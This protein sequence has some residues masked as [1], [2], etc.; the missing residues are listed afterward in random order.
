VRD[1]Q[2]PGSMPGENI[3]HLPPDVDALFLEARQAMSTNAHTAAVLAFRKLLMHIAVDCGAQPSESFVAYVQ[4][5]EDNHYVPPRAK[6]WVDRIR[7]RG[8]EANHQITLMAK[9]QSEELLAITQMLL[10]LV[11]EYPAIGASP[12]PQNP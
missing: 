7:Q 1:I 3:K 2:F 11:Y 5:L 9:E 8:N 10:K 6:S 12:G 4:Y